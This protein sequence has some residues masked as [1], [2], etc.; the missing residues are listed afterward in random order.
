VSGE[1]AR[2]WRLYRVDEPGE[3]EEPELAAYCAD[4]AER[5]F[6]DVPRTLGGRHEPP[7]LE[8]GLSL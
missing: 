6:G 1:D 2:G 3:D 7:A 5:E 8:D 4:C